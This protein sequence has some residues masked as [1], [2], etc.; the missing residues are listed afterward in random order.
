[1]TKLELESHNIAAILLFSY[2]Y[3][4]LHESTDVDANVVFP[5]QICVAIKP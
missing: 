2:T 5:L 3:T 4:L 1:M